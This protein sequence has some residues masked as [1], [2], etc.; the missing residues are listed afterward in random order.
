MKLIALLLSYV[1]LWIPLQEMPTVQNID[2]IVQSIS[3]GSS[4][5]LA[6]HL[7]ASTSL[8]INGEQGDYSKSQAE[9]VLKDFFKQ[10]PPVSFKMVYSNANSY[11][12]EYKS[13]QESF[14][15]IIKTNQ[16]GGQ[17]RIYS[18]SFVKN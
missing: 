9:L 14:K 3:K 7:D 5:S 15:V 6:A 17:A 13:S 2:S 11:I 18:L 8:T 12:G 10:Y 4:S 1:L 16:V